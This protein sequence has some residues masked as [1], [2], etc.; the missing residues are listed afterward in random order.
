MFLYE[1]VGQLIVTAPEVNRFNFFSSI[2]E[3]L[4]S[5]ME[6]RIQRATATGV[7]DDVSGLWLA[8]AVCALGYTI[9]S[10]TSQVNNCCIYDMVDSFSNK[11]MF[12]LLQHSNGPLASIF[13]KC[14]ELAIQSIRAFQNVNLLRSKVV[15][16]LHRLVYCLDANIIPYLSAILETL[17]TNCDPV[18]MVVVVQ[19][20]N[21]LISKFRG[22]IGET[23]DEV[24]MHVI[25]Q[26]FSA[27]GQP[28]GDTYFFVFTNIFFV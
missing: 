24:L 2:S 17:L 15:F 12:L 5:E 1:L 3:P 10:F 20:L 22:D 23:L 11:N 28:G 26:V 16:L 25:M 18:D 8:R 19:L 6:L 7:A 14:L 13:Q 21:Q 27:V 4:L 9:K